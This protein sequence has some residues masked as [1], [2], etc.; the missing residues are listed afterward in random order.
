MKHYFYFLLS[1]ALVVGCQPTREQESPTQEGSMEYA[2]GF[3]IEALGSARLVEVTQPYPGARESITYLLVPRGEEVPKGY[4][5]LSVITTPVTRMVCTSTTH[6]PLL[7]Y[8]GATETLVGFPSHDYISSEKMRA[9]IHAGHVV[10][11]GM[12]KGLNRELLAELQPDMVMAYSMSKDFGNFQKI[13]EMGIPVVINAEFLEEH[14]LGRAEWIKLAGALLGKE[15][16]AD[17]IFSGIRHA[18][19]RLQAMG[20]SVSSK[21]TVLSGILYN[22]G[23]YLP[24]GKNYA[25]VILNDAGGQYLWAEDPSS[26]FLNLSFESVAEKALEADVWI[27]VA[28]FRSLEE[29]ARSDTRY[30]LFEAFKKGKVYSYN[31]RMGAKGGSEYLELGYLRPDLIL[32]DLIK[33]MHPNLL[34]THEL[35]FYFPLK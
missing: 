34:P 35:F 20:Q 13:E 11:L 8:L 23:W 21:P 18:Y 26:S 9:R 31:A 4:E 25:S 15:Q 27:G 19:L 24:G 16:E 22:D 6:I 2:T 1:T 3:T 10:D 12:D 14:P 30:T 28:S 33:I 5:H 7:D 17:S 32:A 29:M